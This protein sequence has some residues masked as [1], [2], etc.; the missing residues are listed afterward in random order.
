MSNIMGFGSMTFAETAFSRP[1]FIGA[2]VY[3]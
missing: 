2:I 1:R 3:Q